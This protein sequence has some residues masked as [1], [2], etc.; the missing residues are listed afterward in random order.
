MSGHPSKLPL[1]N[2]AVVETFLEG[3]DPIATIDAECIL[4]SALLHSCDRRDCCNPA[5]LSAG[6]HRDNMADMVSKGRQTEGEVLSAPKRGVSNPQA[7]LTESD[8]RRIRS[9]V[10]TMP[11]REIA[12][13]FG[14]GQARVS[15]IATGKAWG[16]V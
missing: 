4:R 9:L 16:H 2:E 10:G 6:T 5:H 14:V 8:V 7:K 1:P 12:T 15:D 11:Q 13:M 3:L